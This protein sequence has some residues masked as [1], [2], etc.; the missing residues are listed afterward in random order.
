MGKSLGNGYPMGA[1]VTTRDIA[2]SLGEYYSTFG[3]NPVACVV[4]MAVLDVIENEKLVPSAK[5]VGKTLIESLHQLRLKYDCIGDVR[6]SG[7]C[8]GIEIVESKMNRKP[9]R[10]LTEIITYK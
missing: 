6:G 1:V 2:E 9:N 10:E 5:A 8:I 3:G 7:L 4:G